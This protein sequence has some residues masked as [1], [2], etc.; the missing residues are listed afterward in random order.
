MA[1]HKPKDKAESPNQP[2]VSPEDRQLANLKL[3]EKRL[4]DKIANRIPKFKEPTPGAREQALERAQ[5]YLEEIQA[6]IKNFTP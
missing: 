6:A 5:R 4:K 2:V 3:I 1:N